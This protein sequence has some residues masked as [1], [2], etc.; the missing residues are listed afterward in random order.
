MSPG[1]TILLVVVAV[2]AGISLIGL[3][4]DVVVG[5]VV[6]GIAS[7]VEAVA[8]WTARAVRRLTPARRP[9]SH[10]LAGRRATSVGARL[11]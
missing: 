1:V 10:E 6:F 4:G 5:W 9:R 8:S 7:L 2:F 11:P 3:Y